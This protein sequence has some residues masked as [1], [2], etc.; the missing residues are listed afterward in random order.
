MAI[1]LFYLSFSCFVVMCMLFQLISLAE[2]LI[3]PRQNDTPTPRSISK[4]ISHDDPPAYAETGN[5]KDPT[6]A[7]PAFASRDKVC[8]CL[9]MTSSI[10]C[11]RLDSFSLFLQVQ[12]AAKPARQDDIIKFVVIFLLG[13]VLGKLFL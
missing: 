3:S 12:Q 8:H 7:A 4:S 2:L 10:I 13:L 6:S 11:V 9:Y 1:I 5:P